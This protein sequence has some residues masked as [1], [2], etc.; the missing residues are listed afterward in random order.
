M[1]S[2]PK[3][4]PRDEK[5]S[6]TSGSAGKP[7]P[8]ATAE[9][10][11][12]SHLSKLFQVNAKPADGSVLPLA[13]RRPSRSW[14]FLGLLVLALA[15]A[16]GVRLS[17]RAQQPDLQEPP[18]EPPP[19]ATAPGEQAPPDNAQ[20]ATPMATEEAAQTNTPIVVEEII[21]TNGP[22]QDESS[23]AP[24]HRFRRSYRRRSGTGTGLS[25]D[26]SFPTGF[27]DSVAPTNGRPA[28]TN[29]S[30]ILKNNI[31]DPYRHPNFIRAE[32]QYTRTVSVESFSLCGT[33]SYGT[34][35]FAVFDGSS[36]QYHKD[37]RVADSIATYKVTAI[38]PDMVTLVTGTNTVELRVG[39]QMRREEN[40]PWTMSE[41]S[42]HPEGLASTTASSASS[43]AGSATNVDP[44]MSGPDSEVLKRLMKAREQE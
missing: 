38:A 7:Q 9:T 26:G 41:A 37:V 30:V 1:S 3:N 19:D 16:G 6:A 34:D 25:G 2:K 13:P 5:A 21:Q 33:A 42:S 39:M 18:P 32:R 14:R 40:G 29:F 28:F 35:L 8:D 12:R 17:A 4:Q 43:A 15:S 24:S 44:P 11:R 31:F 20:P 36:S 10:R 23:N 22:A 27:A